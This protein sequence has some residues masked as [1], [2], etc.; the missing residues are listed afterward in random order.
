MDPNR[1]MDDLRTI[2]QI[3][4]RT[5]RTSAGEGGW[6][7]VAAG[8][9]WL[10]GFLGQQFLPPRLVGWGWLVANGLGLGTIAWLAARMMRRSAIKSPIFGVIM[11]WWL[12]LFV[13]DV[14]LAWLF[15]LDAASS[16][17]LL[18]VLT[19]ALGYIQFGL[20]THWIISVTGFLLAVLTVAAWLL[21]PAYFC[22]AVGV[23]GGGT[24]VA[25]GLWLARQKGE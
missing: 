11:L 12:A 24:L 2:R 10:L 7:M 15:R 20:F 16:I 13:F 3:M 9:M 1:A 8:V 21:A 4:D 19:I 17:S 14:L 25:S 6:F 22:L 5:R 18:I 23:L